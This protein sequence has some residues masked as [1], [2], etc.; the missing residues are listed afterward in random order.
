MRR[1]RCTDAARA[2]RADPADPVARVEPADP[3]E[4]AEPVAR[5]EPVAQAG[6]RVLCRL[7]LTAPAR[8][9]RL[10]E[11]FADNLAHRDGSVRECGAGRCR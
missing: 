4:P 1:Q 5:A 9:A 8:L 6:S 10:S 7:A 2:A 3:A 11:E